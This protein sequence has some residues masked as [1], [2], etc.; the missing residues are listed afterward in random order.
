M[1]QYGDIESDHEE[2]DQEMQ[3]PEN[4]S[5]K[6][7]TEPSLGRGWLD[8]SNLQQAKCA[9]ISLCAWGEG[10]LQNQKLIKMS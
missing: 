6:I 3:G 9:I 4:V 5:N 8:E 7:C 10:R 1:K 2:S